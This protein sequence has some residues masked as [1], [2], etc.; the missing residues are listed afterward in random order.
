MSVRRFCLLLDAAKGG[1]NDRKWFPRWVR[2]YASSVHV[3]EMCQIGKRVRYK[4]DARLAQTPLQSSRNSDQF[5]TSRGANY[6]PV[7]NSAAIS[8]SASSSLSEAA[9]STRFVPSHV[10]YPPS[11]C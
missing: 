1:K 5:K 3:S 11:L 8:R 9:S 7:F 10:S 4:A 2:S 6:P